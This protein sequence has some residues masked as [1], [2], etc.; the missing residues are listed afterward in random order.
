VV[1][2][3]AIPGVAGEQAICMR[4]LPGP[5]AVSVVTGPAVF[6]AD[7]GTGGGA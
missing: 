1:L 5:A 3:R 2:Y 4:L 6:I 7:A